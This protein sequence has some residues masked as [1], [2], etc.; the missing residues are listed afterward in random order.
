M[1]SPKITS[2]TI[3]MPDGTHVSLTP[4]AAR[5]LYK[6]LGELFGAQRIEQTASNVKNLLDK[7][8]EVEED[9]RRKAPYPH[10]PWDTPYWN[11]SVPSPQWPYTITCISS[12]AGLA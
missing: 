4:D 8:K 2:I 12:N 10:R 3:V 5:D 11:P 9:T 6:Q 7:M 1:S